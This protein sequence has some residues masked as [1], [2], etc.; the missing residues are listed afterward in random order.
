MT[1]QQR[2]QYNVCLW[3]CYKVTDSNISEKGPCVCAHQ[4]MYNADVP[5]VLFEPLMHV[6]TYTV[7]VLQSRSSSRLPATLWNLHTQ[8]NYEFYQVRY[9]TE[10]QLQYVLTID[11]VD[12]IFKSEW[13]HYLANNIL[14]KKR[15]GKNND[16]LWTGFLI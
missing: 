3:T 9:G 4:T 7:Q 6:L 14:K 16:Y 15:N 13:C 5:L 10:K 8:H 11:R 2:Q 1:Y 12:T